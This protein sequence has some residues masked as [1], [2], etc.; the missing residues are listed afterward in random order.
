M[1]KRF[2][3][4]NKSALLLC[5]LL[6]AGLIFISTSCG[7][8]TDSNMLHSGFFIANWYGYSGITEGENATAQIPFVSV[9]TDKNSDEY[10]PALSFDS[11]EVSVTIDG[12]PFTKPGIISWKKGNTI[13][14]FTFYTLTLDLPELKEGLHRITEIKIPVGKKELY[15]PL[16]WIVD[17]RNANEISKCVSVKGQ[18]TLSGSI[19]T[20][21][22]CKLRNN[23]S[24]QQI[25]KSVYFKLPGYTFNEHLCVTEQENNISEDTAPPNGKKSPIPSLDAEKDKIVVNGFSEKWIHINLTLPNGKKAPDFL[26]IKPFVIYASPGDETEKLSEFY[27][28]VI[29]SELPQTEKET[30][31]LLISD[32]I[33]GKTAP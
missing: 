15:Y 33:N 2:P 23:C 27:S 19:S 13:G 30:E 3:A 11:K 17:T 9:C 14:K 10:Q 22:D 25:V 18:S 31:K 26:S 6:A 1:K 12:Q 29:F 28:P 5:I 7:E 16:H 24:G 20:G 4:L 8:K 32:F 21:I